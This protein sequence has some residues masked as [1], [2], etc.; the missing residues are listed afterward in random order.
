MMPGME[1]GMTLGTSPGRKVGV[2]VGSGCGKEPLGKGVS[3]TPGL[4]VGATEH[5]GTWQ[6]GSWGLVTSWQ[7]AW[8]WYV[9]H[10]VQRVSS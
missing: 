2:W 6:H 8:S 7:P 9:G 3:G 1:V 10:L 4:G 5:C